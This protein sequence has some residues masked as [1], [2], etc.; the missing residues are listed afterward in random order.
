M[1]SARIIN[2]TLFKRLATV[3]SHA[4][5][6]S[7]FDVTSSARHSVSYC[8]KKSIAKANSV[9]HKNKVQ[10][11]FAEVVKENTK[12]LGY[13]GVI[14]GGVGIVG[15][16]F[17]IVFNELFSSKSPTKVY[18]KALDRCIKDPKVVDA[19]G[20]PIKGYGE[21]SRRGRRTHVNHVIFV[22][23]GVQHMRMKFYVQGIRRRG[24]VT[25][26]VQ[27]NESGNYVYKYLYVFIDDLM[28]TAIKIED[29]RDGQKSYSNE[30][31]FDLS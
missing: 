8:T 10:I 28:R 26:E 16:M 30:T 31:E 29:N 21:E 9:E 2:Y 23:D 20:E 11:G 24:T 25:L 22:K 12:S 4:H 14:V 3:S 13:L 6:Y 17:Y 1:A 27:E 7:H 15:L 18:S 5:I 19:L